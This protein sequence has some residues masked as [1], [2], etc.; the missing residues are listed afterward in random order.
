M[1]YINKEFY[2]SCENLVKAGDLLDCEVGVIE[3]MPVIMPEEYPEANLREFY[4]CSDEF[5]DF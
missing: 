2:G 4:L 3:E 5:R 1:E